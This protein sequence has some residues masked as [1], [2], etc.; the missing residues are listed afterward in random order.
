MQNYS[1]QGLLV[2]CLLPLLTALLIVDT[3]AASDFV[4][5]AEDFN[6]GGG[7][8][9][10]RSDTMPY[11]GGAY[12]TLSAVAN[13]DYA[14]NDVNDSVV[15]RLGLSP[16]VDITQNA[17]L[18]RDSWMVTANY[19]IGWTDTGDWYNYTRNLPA[20]YYVPYAALSHASTADH[21]LKGT[22]WQ[23][24]SAANTTNQTLV[25]LGTFDAPG[26]GGW[27]LNNRVPLTDTNGSAVVL[28]L[29]GLMTLRYAAESADIDYYI[30]K[31]V[32][33]PQ[34]S[35]QPTNLTV[36]EGGSAAFSVQ[37]V[38]PLATTYQWLR[39]LV[40][41]PAAT[42]SSYLL[43]PVSL[44]DSNSQFSCFISNVVGNT[45]SGAATLTV[46]PDTT[47]PSLLR[48]FNVGTTNVWIVFSEPVE[49][50]SATNLLNYAL[51]GG[52]SISSAAF[53]P[54]TKTIVL[55]TPPLTYSTSYA[56]T[57]SNVRDRAASPNTIAANSQLTFTAT[58]YAPSDIGNPGLSGYITATTNGF[59]VVGGGSDI[60]GTADQF[61]FAYQL[62][63]GDFDVKARIQS[64]D[65]VNTWAKA[66]LMARET[67]DPGSRFAATLTTPAMVGSFFEW[68]DPASSASQFSGQL[69]VNYPN[70]W[71]RLKRSGN[72][73][74]GFASYDGQTWTQLGSAA[75]ALPSQVYLGLAV[76]SH[77]ASQPTTAQFR[78]VADVSNGL[79]GPVASPYEPLGPCS[80]RTPLVISELMY[81]PT[82]RT[83]G[84][85]LQYVELYNS[86][87]WWED[88]SGYRLTG[89]ILYTVPP[90]TILP[91]GAFLVVS[92]APADLQTVYGLTRVLGPSVA[93]TKKTGLIQLRDEQG[94][95]LLEFTYGTTLPWPA[96]ANST[97]HSIVLA[98]PSY[99]EADP[100]AWAISDVVGGSPGAPEAYRPGPLR[101]LVINEFLAHPDGSS[102]GYL[103]LYNHSSS[104][105]DF[106]GCVLTDDP[107]TNKFTV[108][109]N[110]VVGPGGLAVFDTAQMGFALNPAGGLVLF[111]TPDGSQVLD[112]VSYE[113]QGLNV[114]C[115]RWPDGAGE[116]Y[117]LAASTPG[118]PN[119]DI[120]IG[121][122][123]LNEIMYKPISGDDN[124]QYVELYNQGTNPVDLGG[125]SFTAG[126]HFTF[127]SNTV[128]SPGA[129]LVVAR[130]QTSLF[131]RYAQLDPGN[132]VGNFTG[133]LPH[134]G[135]RLALARPEDRVA[136]NG[137]GF[138]ST[139]RILVVEDEV[140]YDVGGRWGQWAHGGGSS[141]EL[142]HPR[143]NHRLPDNWADSD[144]SVKSSWTNLEVT[145]VL[146]NGANY[147]SG[148]IDLV[149]L[150][151]LDVGECLV[152]NIEVRPGTSGANYIA[153][154]GFENGLNGWVP[155]GDHI[156]S[157]LETSL[158]GYNSSYCLHLRSSDGVWTLFNSVQGTLTNTTLGAG[159]TATLRFKGRWL[160][161]SP[162]IMMRLRGNWLEV[163]GAFPVPVN[164]GTPGLPNS[165]AVST[166]GPA[167][168]EVKHSPAIPI[169]GQPVLVTARF[170][171]ENGAQP[172][173]LYRVDTGVA[174][175]PTY[176]S[177]IMVDNGAGGDALAGDGIYSARIPAQSAGTVVAFI[178]QGRNALGGATTF[179]RI[180][181]DNSGLPREC[182]VA[183]G[184]PVPLGS[185][186][187][188]H[189][190]MTQNWVNRWASLGGVSN[191]N[192]DGTFV[193]GNSGRI[194]YNW[195]GRYAG[196]PYHQYLGSPAT[197]IG[198][199]HWTVPEDNKFLGSASFNKQHLP[200]NGP[201]DDDTLQREQASYWMARQ[202]GVPWGYRRFYIFYLNGNRHGPL[203]EDSQVPGADMIKQRWPND[204]NGFL[205]KNHAW[206]EGATALDA[207]GYMNFNGE[208]SCLLDRFTTTINGVPG[209]Y[210]L[211][212]YR[213][214]YWIRQYPDSANNFTNVF[215][216][217]TAANLPPGSP[218]Y[219]SSLEALADTE[220]FMRMSAL[221]HATGDW[222]DWFTQSLWNMYIYKPSRGKWTA[223][224]WDWN[225]TLGSG[226]T[227]WP[228][229]GSQL[230]TFTGDP[231]MAGFQNYPPHLRAYLR[232]LKEIAAKAMNNTYAGPELDK[233]YA[234]FVDNGLTTTAYNGLTV[235]DPGIAG[236]LKSW[237]GAMH[238]SLLRALTNQG[239]ASLTFAITGPT[240][241]LTRTNLA[242]LTGT[243]PVEV[244][245]ITVNGAL[246]PLTW[247]TVQAWRMVVP[248]VGATNNLVLQ[249][250]DLRGNLLSNLT[251]SL[252]IINTNAVPITLKPVVIN[253]WMAN[254]NNILSDPADGQVHDWFELYNPNFAIVDLSGF[255][256][257]DKLS[258]K[259]M[260]QI[261][262]GAVLS[263]YGFILVWAD[264]ALSSPG[265]DLHANF[266]L[267]KAG[268][269][270]GLFDPLGNLVDAINYGPQQADV[271]QGR[272][273]DG[274]P[275]IY[276]MTFPTPKAPN[277][278]TNS[279][280][281]LAAVADQSAWAGNLLAFVAS[282]TD[283]DS[284]PQTL[285]FS[286]NAGAP[287]GAVINATNGAFTWLVP[288]GQPPGTNLITV[289]VTDNGIPPLSAARS[290][291][292]VVHRLM[293]SGIGWTPDGQPTFAWSALPGRSYRVEWKANLSD[294]AWQMLA[295]LYASAATLS[296]TD[297]TVPVAAQR[298]Y[299]ITLLP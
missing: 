148:T 23:L 97:G 95:I 239:V 137:V 164:L 184:D 270:I 231:I 35:Q 125:W 59:D 117:P 248:L 112:A 29:Q 268:S 105:V 74:S 190:W 267:A 299:R 42:N 281:V 113:A 99:G 290:V 39:N 162:E 237:I 130:D 273:P 298:F 228:P 294:P 189:V 51:S 275:I 288:T 208:S 235:R 259:T 192:H 54:D 274:S 221:Q 26:S 147:N 160:R 168:Y 145:G 163:T 86:N 159:S 191:E 249:A 176:Q 295:D 172:K 201:L 265:Y 149:Q 203:M 212:R 100:R 77:A 22:L 33:F 90:G 85:N 52:V 57:V 128:V 292:V 2:T 43:D 132:T 143:T 126:I 177:V 31:A 297:Q 109:A 93:A 179:P 13:V 182:V 120:L 169:A 124:D 216:L 79:I 158:G 153:N 16:N 14:N 241:F 111:K 166:P 138:A 180:L 234:A 253:E 84:R 286:L 40:N 174:P 11:Y 206:F 49:A 156:R 91:G 296:Y 12:N 134:K 256:L 271:S 37:L 102:S 227:T 207:S 1:A 283:P 101:N 36:V 211:G 287:A 133:K 161:G 63:L 218:A 146:D 151:L 76:S 252:K 230:F 81:N 15:Y 262:P 224:K 183:F 62:R 140:T 82:P 70:T 154:A 282:A 251:A 5:E 204:D 106:S 131:S 222:D 104:A 144:E 94:A 220:E 136:T 141:L 110:S 44:T 173:L 66:G 210:K 254:N 187:H 232:A 122:I 45:T 139:N 247:T 65:Q 229:D 200:G 245:S 276:F 92:P 4:I 3:H 197:T 167:I 121:D 116:F 155:Q 185:F 199:Q 243:A 34:I 202:L 289:R 75:I 188:E 264:G 142:I 118:A 196:S 150:G 24:T 96:G 260:W 205:Y 186:D 9:V 88:I 258:N 56:L 114:S 244:K 238:D 73:F 21:M 123:V 129:Y 284:P 266:K 78:D 7:Q 255:Y 53:G 195:V 119:A 293:I 67:L 280:P 41:I 223:L 170:H 38:Q 107:Q 198:G 261:P 72:T 64:V 20:G 87:P 47:P 269:S 46:F 19:R 30:F 242:A 27:G 25:Q 226:T 50:V 181:N 61:Q 193:D 10:P 8:H 279:P 272:W 18:N 217:I 236:G 225:I 233:K 194:I 263:P 60:G 58:P 28:H 240:N 171:D 127:A 83:D 209:Q 291:A 152:D 285:T 165:Q 103:E 215:A 55:T 32:Q 69:P 157:N 213:W 135:G 80:R 108:P 68:R 89:D 17:D 178:I 219:N 257:T 214:M 277:Q 250:F 278:F 71:L 175:A 48:T 6:Y 98:R 115:G 246:L